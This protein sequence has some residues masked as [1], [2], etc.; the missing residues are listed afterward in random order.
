MALDAVQKSAKAANVASAISSGGDIAATAITLIGSI[1][2]KNKRAAFQNTFSLLELDQKE[3]LEKLLIEANSETERL[4]IL[5][6]ALTSVNLQRVSNI[7]EMYAQRERKLRNEKL[8]IGGGVL[9]AG[10]IIVILI[11]KSK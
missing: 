5:T 10:L 7:A 11:V 1:K 6:K 9:V 8:L 4:S 2:D 3:K